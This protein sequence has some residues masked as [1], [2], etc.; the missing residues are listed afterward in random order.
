MRINPIIRNFFLFLLTTASV[1]G[2][3]L[4]S[5]DDG[6][7]S[8]LNEFSNA[9]KMISVSGNF[10]A[11][12]NFMTNSFVNLNFQND[13]FVTEEIKDDMARKMKKKNNRLGTESNF[14][15]NYKFFAER[16][17][18]K[19][20]MAI[21]IG[22]GIRDVQYLNISKDAF[23]LYFRGNAPY[24]GEVKN[25]EAKVTTFLLN[26]IRLGVEHVEDGNKWGFGTSLVLGAQYQNLKLRQGDLFTQQD[27]EYIDFDTDLELSYVGD[28]DE[29]FYN[30][31]GAG[32]AF[33]LFFQKQVNKTDHF[34]FSV[35]DLG[36]VQ[37]FNAYNVKADTNIHFEGIEVTNVF[38]F[39]EDNYEFPSD[40]LLEFF[41]LEAETKN[42]TQWLPTMLTAS[43]Y[44]QF[45]DKISLTAGVRYIINAAYIPKLF[46][47]GTYG[48]REVLQLNAIAN[49]GGYGNLLFG[50]GVDKLFGE[51]LGLNLNLYMLGR[52]IAP[53]T[54]TGQ[55]ADIKLYMLF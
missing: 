49:I 29:Y 10:F 24:A 47:V 39:N 35:A 27:G 9:S 23:D 42:K 14:F 18:G 2:Q 32:I 55:A 11:N 19:D 48:K 44:K 36:L 52:T 51:K 37:W 3:G 45:T 4:V 22:Y 41:G 26:Q 38:D 17:L 12:S 28:G 30:I 7:G 8:Q 50:L 54:T 13:L 34:R 16:F 6:F 25:A 15:V 20:S 5:Y 31:N 33:D 1:H 43:Y 53:S 40:S 21:S 46:L